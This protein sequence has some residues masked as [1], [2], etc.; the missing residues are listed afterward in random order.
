MKGLLLAA[1][2]LLQDG[3]LD[4]L[5]L[6]LGDADPVVRSRA[7]DTL[8]AR[9]ADARDV[10]LKGRDH[11]DPEIRSRASTLLFRLDQSVLLAKLEKLQRQVK[12]NR[13]VV[14]DWKAPENSAATEGGVFAFSRRAWKPGGG[15]AVGVIFST[16][17][18]QHMEGEIEWSVAGIRDDRNI[19]VET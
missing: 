6:Q 17:V 4:R 5:L 15:P 2:L 13:Y 18:H 19:T 14:G 3:E 1:L 11:A 16:V 9:G 8:A 12:L 7:S 10:L